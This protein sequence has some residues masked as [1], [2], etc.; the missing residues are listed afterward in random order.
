MDFE[1]LEDLAVE[2]NLARNQNMRSKAKK[3]EEELLSHLTENQLFFPIEEEV[4]INKNS[5]SY[6]YKKNKTY[7]ALLEY[8][9]RILHVDIPIRIK[10]CKFGPGGIIVAAENKEE[11]KKTLHDCCHE[12]QILIK[13]KEGHID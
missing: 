10:Q 11:A 13:A 6:V 12:L 2:A 7:P 4:L 1:K 9:A 5:A 8:I 3:L